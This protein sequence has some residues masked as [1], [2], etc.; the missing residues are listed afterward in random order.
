MNNENTA[1]MAE[2]REMINF[3]KTNKIRF[4]TGVTWRQNNKWVPSG[5]IS[6]S[7]EINLFELLKIISNPKIVRDFEEPKS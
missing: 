5:N 4:T 6:F 7:E 1:A 2:K 3:L